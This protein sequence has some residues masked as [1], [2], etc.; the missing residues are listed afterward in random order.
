ME[1]AGSSVVKSEVDIETFVAHKD[2][3]DQ[4]T[5]ATSSSGGAKNV[6][7]GKDHGV[8]MEVDPLVKAHSALDQIKNSYGDDKFSDIDS[9]KVLHNL[10]KHDLQVKL[11]IDNNESKSNAVSE[12]NDANSV[13]EGRKR[14]IVIG[15]GPVGLATARNFQ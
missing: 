9:A 1:A 11:Q 15:G 2:N 7:L 12:A 14:I 4:G 3:E 8:K 6:F 13:L 10:H 5:R